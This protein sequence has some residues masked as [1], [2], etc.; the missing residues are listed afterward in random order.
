[1]SWAGALSIPAAI[2]LLAVVSRLSLRVYPHEP[3]FTDWPVRMSSPALISL[4]AGRLPACL[5]SC[6]FGLPL[7]LSTY[8]F[9][10]HRNTMTTPFKQFPRGSINDSD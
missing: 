3:A 4:T 10:R 7:A 5:P 1:M 2:K 6:K 9:P 8:H